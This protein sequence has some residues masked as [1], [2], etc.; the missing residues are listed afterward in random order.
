M[1]I[2]LKELRTTPWMLVSGELRKDAPFFVTVGMLCGMVQVVGYR[3]FDKANWGSKLLEEHI[4]FNSLLLTVMFLWFAKGLA[5]W[6]C[7]KRE[8]PRTKGLIA[9][10]SSRAVAFASVAA[11]VVAGF[12]ITAAISSAYF[13][14]SMFLL[15]CAYL[16][17]LAEIAANPLFGVGQSKA[18]ALAMG[19]VIG[20]PLGFHL[21]A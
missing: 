3:Y 8:M 4:A 9:H 18:Y 19:V 10:I 20:L 15:F 16:V 6:L 1:E 7:A 5:E 14:A 2:I 21:I 13:H 17:S 11:S 12:A